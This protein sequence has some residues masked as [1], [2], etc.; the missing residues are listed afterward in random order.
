MFESSCDLAPKILVAKG[1]YKTKPENWP[2]DVLYEDEDMFVSSVYDIGAS[3]YKGQYL[4]R[5]DIYDKK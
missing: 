2:F 5:I 4:V 3:A 1:K